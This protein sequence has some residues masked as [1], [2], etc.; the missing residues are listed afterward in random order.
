M[1]LKAKIRRKQLEVFLTVLTIT[2]QGSTQKKNNYGH[3]ID[4][5]LQDGNKLASGYQSYRER[6]RFSE[7]VTF[8]N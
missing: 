2:C 5:Y 7:G 8:A 1:K 6:G 3:K 4:I